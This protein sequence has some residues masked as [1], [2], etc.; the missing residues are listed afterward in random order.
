MFSPTRARRIE[1]NEIKPFVDLKVFGEISSIRSSQGDVFFCDLS[2][3][4]I[5]VKYLQEC[6]KVCNLFNGWE[7]KVT[8]FIMIT[9]LILMSH[10]KKQQLN[11]G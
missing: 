5:R 1:G 4:V 8:P 2:V 6:I 7:T 9:D 11:Y 10:G 3:Q